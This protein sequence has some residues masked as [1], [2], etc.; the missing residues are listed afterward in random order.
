LYDALVAEYLLALRFVPGEPSA[1]VD[2]ARA[3]LSPDR[4]AAPVALRPP[5]G[6]PRQVSRHRASRD[7]PG[8]SNRH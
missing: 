5:N 6:F 4:G 2:L 8:P 1:E 7:E 3:V